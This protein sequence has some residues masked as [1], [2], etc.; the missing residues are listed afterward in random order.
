MMSDVIDFTRKLVEKQNQ[1][2]KVFAV[3]SWEILNE[4]KDDFIKTEKNDDDK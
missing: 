1:E 3:E 4:F 2:A